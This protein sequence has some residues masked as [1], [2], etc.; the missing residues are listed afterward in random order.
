MRC[1]SELRGCDLGG[2][3]SSCCS[4]E[5]ESW[6]VEGRKE[7]RTN[8]QRLWSERTTRWSKQG[9]ELLKWSESLHFITEYSTCDC[10]PCVRRVLFGFTNGGASVSLIG[11]RSGSMVKSH[12]AGSQNEGSRQRRGEGP[13]M[14]FRLSGRTKNQPPKGTSRLGRRRPWLQ[15]SPCCIAMRS[16]W[17][18][19]L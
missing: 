11:S 9:G 1:Q 8:D 12:P 14:A 17:S 15:L 19:P 16:G 2:R 10:A 4:K 13:C 3:S 6:A 7:D 5:D 18:H